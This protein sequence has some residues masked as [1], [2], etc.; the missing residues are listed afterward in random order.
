MSYEVKSV[1]NGK[2]IISSNLVHLNGEKEFEI[3]VDAWS[4]IVRFKSDEG[5]SRYRGVIEG[6][7]LYLDLYNHTN[8]LSEAIFKP[9]AIA[10]DK[11][12][13]IYLTYF[14]QLIDPASEIRRFEYALW[15][16]EN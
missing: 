13:D 14:T 16:D 15:M 10:G 12:G 8:Q 2:K 5:E 11:R 3:F 7:K 6:E 4:C 1:V 9:F